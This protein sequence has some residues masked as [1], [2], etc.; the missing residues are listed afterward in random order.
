MPFPL[1]SV[2]SLLRRFDPLRGAVAPP[3]K[4]LPP[5][6]HQGEGSQSSMQGLPTVSALKTRATAQ[7]PKGQSA[8]AYEGEPLGRFTGEA[9]TAPEGRNAR[10]RGPRMPC[11]ASK[12]PWAASTMGRGKRPLL[13]PSQT[14]GADTS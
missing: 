7:A 10:Y 1:S 2:A 3:L 4:R 6:G 11:T 14:W 13:S 9:A 12:G 5:V 8:A